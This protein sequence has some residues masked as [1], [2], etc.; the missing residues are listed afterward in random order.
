MV[1]IDATM[2]L[3]LLRPGTPVPGDRNGVA[4]T[5]PK[6]RVDYLVNR[7]ETDGAKILIPS[8]VL[9]EVLVRAGAATSDIVDKLNKYAVF[10]I[11]PFE[12]LA[13]IEVAEMARQELGRKRPDRNMTFAKIKYDRQIVAI[14]K[15]RRVT[16]IYSDDRD[17]AA[18]AKQAKIP[19]IKLA[20]L[21]L[22][23]DPIK[24]AALAG[25]GRFDFPVSEVP[26]V[27]KSA[28]TP[29]PREPPA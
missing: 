12:T 15:V 24:A 23:P 20:D 1:L 4:P 27:E 26:N 18:L 7:L 21:P 13:A 19:V 5:R 8:P 29:P 3:L 17:I 22:P 10:E 9:S 6:D 14:A 16:A 25:Q 11:C 2:L 28:D